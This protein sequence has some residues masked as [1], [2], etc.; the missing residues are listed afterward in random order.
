M[1]PLDPVCK[2]CVDGKL[3]ECDILFTYGSGVYFTL[4]DGRQIDGDADYRWED[5]TVTVNTK[6]DTLFNGIYEKLHFIKQ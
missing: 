3:L 4:A 6:D 2:I 1:E 5:F